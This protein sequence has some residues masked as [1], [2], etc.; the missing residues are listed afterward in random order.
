VSLF[1]FAVAFGIVDFST[2]APTTA[3]STVIFGRRAAGTV[4]GLVAL[5]HQIGSALGSYLG[6]L[7]HDATGSYAG[8]FVAGAALSGVAAFMAWAI[9]AAPTPAAEGA[10][11]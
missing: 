11:A 8:F 10:P 5:S 7:V 9:S 4:F 2:V 3:L 6:G 1:V